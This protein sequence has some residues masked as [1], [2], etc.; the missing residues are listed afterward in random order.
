MK[1]LVILA[2]PYMD[3]SR[4]NKVFMN[5][6]LKDKDISFLSLQEE[7]SNKEIDI[8]KEQN[9]LL[10]HDRIVF[11]F[12]MFWY[13]APGILKT[14]LDSVFGYEF[15]FGSNGSKLKDKE[16]MMC[17]SLGGERGKYEEYTVDDCLKTYELTAKYAQMRVLP[18]FVVYGVTTLTEEEILNLSKEYLDHIKRV[19]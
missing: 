1:V 6:V 5:E 11:Q 18:T 2:H 13:S 4:V 19:F 7:Y 9:R 15:A 12:P 14:Y 3:Y 8:I 10:D 16:F 17:V